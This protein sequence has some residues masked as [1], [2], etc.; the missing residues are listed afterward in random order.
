MSVWKEETEKAQHPV[1]IQGM[2]A[3]E[4]EAIGQGAGR[5]ENAGVDGPFTIVIRKDGKNCRERYEQR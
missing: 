4:K 2:A 3:L 5:V 1:F